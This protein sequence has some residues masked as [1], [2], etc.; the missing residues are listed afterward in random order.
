[1]DNQA[2]GSVPRDDGEVLDD[3]AESRRVEEA[4]SEL[5]DDQRRVLSEVYLRRR[6][7][8]ETAQTLHISAGTVT[9]R[10]HSALQMLRA[11]LERRGPAP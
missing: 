5:S 9:R 1:M 8:A 6:S 11:S 4:L 2:I 10:T 7:V 3:L